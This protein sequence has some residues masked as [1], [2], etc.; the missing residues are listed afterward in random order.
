MGCYS[1]GE[2]LRAGFVD[3]LARVSNAAE[4]HELCLSTDGCRFFTYYGDATAEVACY[5]YVDCPELSNAACNGCVSGEAACAVRG[6]CPPVPAEPDIVISGT[7]DCNT[8]FEGDT[9]GFP[10]DTSLET[11]GVAELNRLPTMWIEFYDPDTEF[12]SITFDTCTTSFDN[13]FGI[14]QVL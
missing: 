4:C 11:C 5:A 6:D 14:F 12:T 1:E 8:P 13:Q 2:C 10:V 7:L 3:S 9:T